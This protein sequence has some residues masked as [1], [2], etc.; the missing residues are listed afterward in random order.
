M[1]RVQ[2]PDSLKQE[3]AKTA[4]HRLVALVWAGLIIGF[5]IYA[6]LV[7]GIVVDRH[8]Q[9]LPT[10][11]F[12]FWAAGKTAIAGHAAEIYNFPFFH[13][14]QAQMIG[15][16]ISAIYPWPYPPLFFFVV[17]V[18]GLIP[19]PLAYLCWIV[20]T[21]SAYLICTKVICRDWKPAITFGGSPAALQCFLVGQN[22]LFTASLFGAFLVTLENRPL[23]SG[24]IL[25]ALTYKPQFGL[26][27]PLALLAGGHWRT[28][29]AAILG[30]AI[31]VAIWFVIDPNVFPALLHA[32][33]T[34]SHD[35]LG[36]GVLNWRKMQSVYALLRLLG[37]TP[38]P[39]GII[40]GVFAAIAALAVWLAWRS[41]ISFPSKAAILVVSTL[42]A[43]PYSFLYDFPIMTVG[44]GFL[45]R[46]RAFDGF[47][48]ASIGTAYAV[49][50]VALLIIFPAGPF[51]L[52]LL[53]PILIRRTFPGM[54]KQSAKAI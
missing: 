35:Y 9:P 4:P 46:D 18:L 33:Q 43:T 13:N 22:G 27:I 7:G 38:T 1:M 32:L 50:A 2:V 5:V 21:L 31:W 53:T 26:L 41:A 30:T 28:I 51:V 24:L 36:A 48:W 34:E 54:I 29:F 16:P 6:V 11:F 17:G 49:M 40:H 12:V 23:L 14:A 44:I 45:F 52:A 10:D 39:A 19:Y 8:G 3:L 25:A 47:E 20:G 37:M 42:A 15:H